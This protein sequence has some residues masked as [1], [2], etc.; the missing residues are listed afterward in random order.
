MQRTLL[1]FQRSF[2]FS[3]LVLIFFHDESFKD[4][5]FLEVPELFERNTAFVAFGNFLYVI[6]EPLQAGHFIFCNDNTIPNDTNLALSGNFTAE[7]IRL[8]LIHI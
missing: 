3:E 8:S 7:D 4:V 5:A 2:Y 6:L 1:H